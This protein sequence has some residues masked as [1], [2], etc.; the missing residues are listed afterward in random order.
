VPG[1]ASLFLVLP[2]S[3]P[4]VHTVDPRNNND[5]HNHLFGTSQRM[6]RGDIKWLDNA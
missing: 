4:V 2:S 6:D 3:L 1:D 5:R